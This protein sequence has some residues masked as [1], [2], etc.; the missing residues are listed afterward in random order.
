MEQYW[1]AAATMNCVWCFQTK[2]RIY[3]TEVE[4][5]VDVWHTE[6]VFL[7]EKEA[8]NYGASQE[9]N[10]REFG[11]GW[12]IWGVPCDGVMADLLGQHNKEFET[13]VEYIGSH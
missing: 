10:N 12:R 6:R 2:R 3:H 8:R 9:H 13:D 5:G 11:K 1:A 4:Q 7:L